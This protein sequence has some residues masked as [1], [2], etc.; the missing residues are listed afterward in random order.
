MPSF[1]TLKHLNLS[2]DNRQKTL[3]RIRQEQSEMIM[4]STWDGDPQSCIAYIYDYFHDNEKELDYGLHPQNDPLKIAVPIKF[5]VYSHNSDGSDQVSYHIQFKP[6]YVCSVDYYE[7]MYEKKYGSQFPVGLYIDIPDG[8]G[9]YRRWLIAEDASRFDFTFNKYSVYP[10]NYNLRWVEDNGKDR[11]LRQM[12]AV[13]R[14]RNSYNAG[15]YTDYVFTRVE[16]QTVIWLPMN[17][18]S[19]KLAY[20]DRLIVSA[21]IDCP[22]T[23]SISKIENT[24][25]FGIN[26]IVLYQDAFHRDT[27]YVNLETGEMYAN[28]YA[29][30]VTPEQSIEDQISYGKIKVSTDNIK[31][32]GGYKTIQVI[33]NDESDDSL[34]SNDVFED[35]W[36]FSIDGNDAA[37]LISVKNVLDADGSP[38]PNVVRIKFDG[39][40]NY[41]SKKLTV[42][43]RSSDGNVTISKELEIT[44]L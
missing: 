34:E 31:I 24:L 22:I 17:S 33:W 40:Y 10:V 12:W 27:D 8:K 18:I 5:I 42:T 26:K 7:D 39:G 15:I 20:N 30:P 4:E 14:M 2:A 35:A 38:I 19:D 16:N 41:L 37:S 1:N 29:S 44:S 28:Y 23:W 13:E 6:S 43:V 9:I 21:P 36:A 25:P 3:G 11:Y 32:G